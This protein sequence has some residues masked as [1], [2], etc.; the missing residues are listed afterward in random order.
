MLLN[1]KNRKNLTRA[2]LRLCDKHVIKIIRGGSTWITLKTYGL[3]NEIGIIQQITFLK[4]DP[5]RLFD[6]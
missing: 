2:H 3:G 6:L 4:H 1:K 5:T